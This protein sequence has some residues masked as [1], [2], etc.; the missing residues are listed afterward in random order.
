MDVS[1]PFSYFPIT[2]RIDG[3]RL[4]IVGGGQIAARKIRLLLDKNAQIEIFAQNLCQEIQ[5]L[6]Q[7]NRVQF[8]GQIE[9]KE[10]FQTHIYGVRLIFA[11]TDDQDYNTQ[12]SQWAQE[13]NI[14]ICA[15]DN[16]QQSSF[17]T[18]AIIDRNPVQIAIST[19]GTAPVLSRR[20]REAIEP[21]ISQATGH[22]ARFMGKHRHWIKKH[23]PVTEERQ[24]LWER[25][26]DGRGPS[27][28]EQN[29]EDQALTYLE[30]LV[31]LNTPIKGEIWLVGAGPGDPDLLTLKAMHCLQNADVILYDHLLSEDVL[32]RIR[33]DALL[34]YVGKQKKKHTLPQQDINQLLI[35]HAQNGKRVLRL[36]GGDPF[37]FGR[38]GEEAEALV[39]AEIPFKIIPGISAANGCAAYSGIP[40]THRDC[41][42][43]CL[44]LTGHTQHEGQLD[45][46]WESMINQQQTL[47]IYMGLSTLHQ[48]C[49]KLIHKGL[50]ST[51]PAAAIEKGTLP[52]QK[53]IAGTLENLSQLVETANLKSPVLV[54]I[55]QVVQ[56]RVISIE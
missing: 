27:F 42:Q 19:G 1:T 12:I 41:A 53:V 31:D 49:Q 22:M 18:P 16:P 43:S 51:W 25:F 26:L 40:L 13:C 3:S 21:I 52:N 38:G 44:I 24:R 30:Q 45:L 4:V 39:K 10:Q 15:V 36:K 55:G 2:L 9:N 29:Q 32:K 5:Q 50:P 46:P 17:I 34:I 54:I 37:I 8:H 14:P 33:R 56:R 6:V 35:K 11:A 28:I 23:L 47:V 20:I 48:L 7:Q